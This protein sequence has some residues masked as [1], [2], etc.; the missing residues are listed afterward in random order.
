MPCYDPQ[1]DEDNKHNNVAAG[2][3]C[4]ILRKI[5]PASELWTPQLVEWWMEHQK[6]DEL[7]RRR[8]DG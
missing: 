3:L 5:H 6:R 2:L 8:N 1:V 4:E 7:Y